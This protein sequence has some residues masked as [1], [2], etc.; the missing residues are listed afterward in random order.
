M[1]Y[2]LSPQAC[3]KWLETRSVYHTASDELYEL[4][5]QSFDFLRDCSS[6]E[7][8]SSDDRALIEYCLHEGILSTEPS[9]RP[10]PPVIKSPKPS[11][12]YLELQITD[13]CNLRCG[14]C[15]IGE[16]SSRELSCDQIRDLL[17]EFQEM[18]GLRV[19]ITGGEPLLHSDFQAI[20]HM[21]PGFM[22]R[23]VLFSNG[24]LITASLLDGLHVDEIQISI[25]GLGDAHDL[26][27]GKGSFRNAMTAL[28]LCREKGFAVSVSTMVHA[29]N[30]GDFDR[31]DGLFR[32]MGVRDWTVDVP[33]VSGRLVGNPAFQVSPAT[34]GRYLGY[35]FGTGLHG[36]SEGYGCGLHLMSVLADGN[37]AKCTF[38]AGRRV[39]TIADSL[40]KCWTRIAP[41]KLE[42]LA[43]D[44]AHLEAC[45][46]GCRYR[47]ELLGS[48]T[49]K[50]LYRC[51]YYDI[52]NQ[53]NGRT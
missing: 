41:V 30:L 11:L 28:R 40:R 37:V 35:G 9:G 7:G 32:D 29:G 15:Y 48:A 34:G 2:Y 42:D 16:S 22:V 23:K 14:H 50:D 44:C 6:A 20:N 8:C 27:R 31:M 47:A 18:Q 51:S 26:L 52:M 1:N 46:G 39:G 36:G 4:D 12:R 3:I 19:L 33:S 43:C 21:L 10:R 5:E 13:R 38:Y 17:S 49:G 25:D 24:H 53:E 45:R